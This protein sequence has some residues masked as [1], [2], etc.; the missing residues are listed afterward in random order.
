MK[1]I[2]LIKRGQEFIVGEYRGHT[3]AE[4]VKG[5]AKGSG[6]P[7]DF[8]KVVHSI[9]CDGA[10][11]VHVQQAFYT[12]ADVK[13]QF[14]RGEKVVAL[15]ASKQMVQGVCRRSAASFYPYDEPKAA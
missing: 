9:E 7:Y 12:V 11:S 6:K 1:L 5:N 2:E 13:E 10:G 3:P 15:I 4:Q 14:K 8:W